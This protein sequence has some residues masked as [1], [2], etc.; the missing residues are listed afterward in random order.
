MTWP[1]RLVALQTIQRHIRSAQA[2]LNVLTHPVLFESLAL[3]EE[4][5]E[6]CMRLVGREGV[7]ASV[8]EIIDKAQTHIAVRS[9]AGTDGRIDRH[10][11]S[12]CDKCEGPHWECTCG[13]RAR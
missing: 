9:V 7:A 10:K 12:W 13:S 4:Q 2:D 3:C 5:I 11:D 6:F 1:E 8:G